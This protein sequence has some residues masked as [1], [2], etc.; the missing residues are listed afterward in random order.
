MERCLATS[1]RLLLVPA[2]SIQKTFKS[3]RGRKRMGQDSIPTEP[4]TQL[5]NSGMAILNE[6]ALSGPTYKSH[7]I[8]EKKM[9]ITFEHCGL[10]PV[11]WR[12]I[13]LKLSLPW[14]CVMLG[15]PIQKNLISIIKKDCLP[16]SSKPFHYGDV[17][18]K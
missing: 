6:V 15:L 8:E 4:L 18:N 17:I 3:T 11:R 16:G 5:P 7:Q 1:S 14:K 9:I 2:R 12:S 10:V 13:I